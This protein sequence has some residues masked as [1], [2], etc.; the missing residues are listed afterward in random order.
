[1]SHVV[2]RILLLFLLIRGSH[3]FVTC[4]SNGS[5][6]DP[7]TP[8]VGA[9]VL[10]SRALQRGLYKTRVNSKEGFI[11]ET[12]ADSLMIDDDE[13]DDDFTSL[14][15]ND[16]DDE[17]EYSFDEDDAEEYSTDADLPVMSL[18]DLSVT[19]FSPKNVSYFYLQ[20]ELELSEKA[21][22]RITYEAGSAL[23]MTAS[24]IRHKV[25]VLKQGMNLSLPNIQLLL[26]RQPTLLHLSAE[27]N[28][29]PTMEF[30]KTQL[31]LD[32]GDLRQLVLASP[33]ILTYQKS[34]LLSKI[35]FFTRDM[36][37]SVK[38]CRNLWLSEPKLI[39]VGVSS[40]LVPR[41][42][43]LTKD[44]EM[45]MENVRRIVQK[46]PRI[47]LYSLDNN[48]IPK[49]V[50]FLIM[51]LQ[52][53]TS[54]IQRLLLSYPALID[55]NLED[56]ILPIARYF[57][58][59]LEYSPAELRSILLKF[60]RLWTYSLR[61]IKRVVGYLRYEVGLAGS[62]VKR[63]LFQAPQ[64]ISL[65]ETHLKEKFVYLQD[66]FRLT[67]D[68]VQTV[69]AGMPTLL[70]L[71]L[72]SNLQPKRDF[73]FE[74]FDYDLEALSAAVLRLPTLLGYSL[75]NRIRPRLE[76]IRQTG[77]DPARITVG[78]PMKQ[79]KFEGWLKRRAAKHRSEEQQ[80]GK[81][82][83]AARNRALYP[84]MKALPPAEMQTTDPEPDRIVHWTRKRRNP[85]S[86]D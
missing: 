38:E 37:Y 57:L 12:P 17:Q 81:G 40:G 48:I 7:N 86:D 44:M 36:G 77:L 1:M 71:S 4:G 16:D 47:L 76:A 18:D 56:H 52:M 72:A 9:L 46:N 64:V 32:K 33:C 39:R 2:P 45:A 66:A 73:L 34:N 20:N 82:L 26:E 65:R 35:R 19:I 24:T 23:G 63:V 10:L 62:Q 21:M 13:D 5:Y 50:F 14:W 51:T 25:D 80:R 58:Q 53:D 43:F 69:V 75:D 11:D 78:I 42:R 3:G 74:A 54:Q 83:E 79:D 55:Y 49:L 8:P 60:P 67:E 29:I 61:K 22:W 70:V 68:Q 30:L 31:R 84:L 6:R 15:D 28:L 59:D 41:L 85:H 27:K